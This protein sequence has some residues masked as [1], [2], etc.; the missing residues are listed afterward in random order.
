[1]KQF[2]MCVVLTATFCCGFVLVRAQD[3]IYKTDRSE[4]KAKVQEIDEDKIR[5]KLFDHLDG[6][7]YTV[8]KREV[9]M[10]IYQNGKRET[11]SSAPLAKA[12]ADPSAIPPGN[13]PAAESDAVA[14]AV[15]ITKTAAAQ[16]KSSDVS[17]FKYAPGRLVLNLV[18]GYDFSL[19]AM[20]E[21]PLSKKLTA[22]Q[23]APIYSYINL[24][25]LASVSSYAD[26]Y[27]GIVVWDLGLYGNWYFPVNKLSGSAK[28]NSGFFPYVY[29]GGLLRSSTVTVE[30]GEA[31]D[32]TDTTG[33]IAF[34]V[35][36]DYRFTKGFGVTARYDADYKFGLGVSFAF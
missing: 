4:I 24:G 1:M 11:F 17:D 21:S 13:R 36:V 34:G 5:Y 19:G 2:Y 15:H 20:I 35:G 7:A 16:T 10:I 28:V 9:F 32:Y 6:P 3:V 29:L 33:D 27:S 18:E 12:E 25:L 31:D 8:P 14:K 23:D 30:Y 26:D 22:Q